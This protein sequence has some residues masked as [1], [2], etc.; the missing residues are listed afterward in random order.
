MA[1][2][3]NQMPIMKP[4]ARAGASLLVMAVA[5]VYWNRRTKRMAREPME[6]AAETGPLFLF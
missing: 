2:D 1:V 3:R 4:A 5:L 6:P